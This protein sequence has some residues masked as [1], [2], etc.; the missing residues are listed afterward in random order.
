MTTPKKQQDD[1]SV[2]DKK[3]AKAGGKPHASE[4]GKSES[5]AAYFQGVKTEWTK[6]SWPTWPQ[7]WAQTVLV[8]VMTLVITLGLLLIDQ[9]LLGLTHLLTD[10]AKS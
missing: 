1:E 10:W 2:K 8:L 5:L 3:S 6:I 9:T 7:I 4:P